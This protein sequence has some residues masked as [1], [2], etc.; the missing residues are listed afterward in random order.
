MLFSDMEMTSRGE[1]EAVRPIIFIAQNLG[2][3]VVKNFLGVSRSGSLVGQTILSATKRG[4]ILGYPAQG[5]TNR[6]GGKDHLQYLPA[7]PQESEHQDSQQLSAKVITQ[8]QGVYFWVKLVVDDLAENL[9]E[10]DSIEELT[11][12][13]GTISL[14]LVDLYMRTGLWKNIAD[15]VWKKHLWLT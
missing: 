7:V 11:G 12:Y 14:E 1:G 3:I 5:L 6:D 8:A 9:R 2:G 4:A 13:L 15:L 10:G